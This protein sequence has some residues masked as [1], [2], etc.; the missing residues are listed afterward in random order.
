MLVDQELSF[1]EDENSKIGCW[2]ECVDILRQYESGL[3]GG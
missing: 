1:S 3:R 2:D